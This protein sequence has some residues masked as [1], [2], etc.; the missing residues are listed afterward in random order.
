M[1]KKLVAALLCV[2]MTCSLFTGCGSEKGTEKSDNSKTESTDGKDGDLESVELTW[3]YRAEEMPEQDQVFA[4]A[5]EILKNK[6]NTT[7]NFVPIAPSD[8][9]QKMQTKYASG[10]AGDINFTSSWAN[11]YAGNVAKGAFIPMDELLEKYAPTVKNLFTEE[12]WNAV[13]IDGKIYGIPNAQIFAKSGNLTVRKDLAEKYNLDIASIHN[14]KD[15][16][17]FMEQACGEN[18]VK[19]ER[20]GLMAGWRDMIYAYGFDDVSQYAYVKA[21]DPELKVVN[22][23]A[24]EEFKEF[25]TIAK[26]WTEKGYIA[27]DAMVKKDME[28]ELKSGKIAARTRGV[29]KPGVEVLE[30]GQWS[31]GTELVATMLGE[32]AL[33]TTS[34]ITSTINAIPATS[35]HPERAMMVLE[36]MNSDKELYNL[37]SYGIEGQHYEIVGDN[38]IKL[39]APDKYKGIPWMMGN[40]FNGYIME[41]TPTDINEKTIEMNNAAVPSEALGF[42]F[43]ANT[44]KNAPQLVLVTYVS[45]RSGFERDGSYSTSKED[46]WESFDTGIATQTFC[47]AAHDYGVGTVIL[48]VFDEETI[49]KIVTL[50][51]GQK[52]AALIAMGYAEGEAPAAPKRKE[53]EALVSYI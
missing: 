39:T 10:E 15:L 43:N 42:T 37:I 41:G 33:L 22:P 32:E 9:E 2:A 30:V 6:I 48:G 16:E 25:C 44:I 11:K 5:N 13:K 46:R 12:Q 26:E 24:T 40:T 50:P 14:L 36:L 4:K 31:A 7:V 49:S 19:L 21:N 38:T 45:G 1:K 29:Y 17:P 52:I 3:Y 27:N 18:D 53:V 51:E 34:G 47:L 28:A 35:K 23:Y 8:F 20:F